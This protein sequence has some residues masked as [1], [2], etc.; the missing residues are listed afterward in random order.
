MA[1]TD[2]GAGLAYQAAVRWVSGRCF[3]NKWAARV[4]QEKSPIRIGRPP[5]WKESTTNRPYVRF[6]SAEWEK[7][8]EELGLGNWLYTL[9]QL[10]VRVAD[11]RATLTLFWAPGGNKA[12]R[13]KMFDRVRDYL[14]TVH[15]AQP[16]CT[17]GYVRLHTVGTFLRNPTTKTG[18]TRKAFATR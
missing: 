3:C 12:L 1:S 16:T 9:L 5:I 4:I 8:E 17:E 7:Y 6:V 2:V 11:R 13:R 18:G 14:D 10:E 15:A